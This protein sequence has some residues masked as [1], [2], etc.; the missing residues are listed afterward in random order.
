M[1]RTRGKA[2]VGGREKTLGGTR[3]GAETRL[4]AVNTDCN[5]QMM[6]WLAENLS[7]FFLKIKDTFSMF[8]NNL[9]DLDILSTSAVS[10]A[11]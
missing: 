4:W 5:M 8:T 7:R 3:W 9:I 11:V 10:Q 2:Q 6:C 1:V